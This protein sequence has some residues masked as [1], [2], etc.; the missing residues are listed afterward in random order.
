MVV[1]IAMAEAVGF[2]AVIAG[3][4]IWRYLLILLH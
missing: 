3:E 4:K 2:I 1:A